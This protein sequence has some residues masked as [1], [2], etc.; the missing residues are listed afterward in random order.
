[1]LDKEQSLDSTSKKKRQW[2]E[3]DTPSKPCL[4]GDMH[5]WR[6]CAYIDTSL[7]TRGFIEDP[8]KAKKIRQYEAQDKK[9]ILS[10]IREKNQRY[11][12]HKNKNDDK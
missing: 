2:Q 4:C 9:G 5:F 8:E 1:M 11:K 3:D 12:K 6:Q 10:K 7:R